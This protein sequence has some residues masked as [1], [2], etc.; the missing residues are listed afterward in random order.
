MVGE[1]GVVWCGGGDVVVV[2]VMYCGR[3]FGSGA[4]MVC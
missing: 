2:M 3:I 1:G 4:G